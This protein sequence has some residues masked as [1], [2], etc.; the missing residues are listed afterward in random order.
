MTRLGQMLYND[1]KEEGEHLHLLM[2]VRKKLEKGKILEVIAD[3]VE[4]D[5]ETIEVLIE[6][7]SGM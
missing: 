5:V 7:M 3:E 4:S 1:W 6:E 2:L